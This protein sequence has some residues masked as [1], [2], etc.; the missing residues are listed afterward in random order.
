MSDLASLDAAARSALAAFHSGIDF[1][2]NIAGVSTRVFAQDADF[3]SVYERVLT[4]CY[5]S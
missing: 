4:V 2:V 3:H 5:L 1:L